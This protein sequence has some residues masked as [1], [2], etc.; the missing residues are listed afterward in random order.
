MI[1]KWSNIKPEA[2]R[3]RKLGK[4]LPYIHT[5]L[6]IPKSTLSY[7]LKDVKLTI[8]Q[9]NK[10][11]NDWKKAL[12]KARSKAVVWHNKAKAHRIKVSESEGR[13]LL[14]NIDYSN[15]YI[16]ELAL[17]LLYLGEGTKAQSETG[18]G[19]SDPVI[20]KFFVN[21]LRTIYKIPEDKIKC[22]LHLRADQDPEK[23]LKFWSNELRISK[24]NFRKPY[25]DKRTAGTK[26]YD[27]YK[28]V[29]LVRCGTVAIQRK[30]V[31]IAKHFCTEVSTKV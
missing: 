29:C 6:G 31:Y 25:L 15:K 14:D 19:S 24:Q 28:G 4:S 3:L 26:T 18:M 13:L 11:E 1:S 27:T 12:I 20:L 17:A 2:I 22:E 23:I 7:W 10:L 9:K 5:K 30:L 21:C 8:A 16:T